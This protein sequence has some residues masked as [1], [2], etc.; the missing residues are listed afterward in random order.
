LAAASADRGLS[1]SAILPA[2]SIHLCYEVADIL[3]AA[4]G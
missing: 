2:A 3:A 4:T 1:R